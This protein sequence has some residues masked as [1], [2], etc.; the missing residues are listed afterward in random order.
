MRQTGSRGTV[1]INEIGGSRIGFALSGER[2][3]AT[4]PY[5]AKDDTLERVN[6]DTVTAESGL[7]MPLQFAAGDMR[8]PDIRR[9]SAGSSRLPSFLQLPLSYRRSRV[10]HSDRLGLSDVPAGRR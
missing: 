3:A 9:R 10:A 5:R 6:A 1:S 7:T 4:R 2:P 8:K